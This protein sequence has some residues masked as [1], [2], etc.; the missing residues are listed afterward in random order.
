MLGLPADAGA[1]LIDADGVLT[2][3]ARVH[4]ADWKQMSDH[5]P[6]Q[7]AARTG[8]R[9]VPARKGRRCLRWPRPRRVVDG[10]VP[11][12]EHLD[13]KPARRFSCVVRVD[14]GGQADALR[15]H[16]GDVVVSDV[17]ELLERP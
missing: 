8:E 9:F 2:Y 17:V 4:A 11:E 7:R 16:G 12:P 15:S 13:G 5:Y 14:R 3:T 6:R 1:C 10:I